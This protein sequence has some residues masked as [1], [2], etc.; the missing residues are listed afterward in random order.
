MEWLKDGRNKLPLRRGGWKRGHFLLNVLVSRWPV[1]TGVSVCVYRLGWEAPFH[2]PCWDQ[3]PH[4]ARENVYP[5]P[6][7]CKSTHTCTHAHTHTRWG[8][9]LPENKHV[10]SVQHLRSTHILFCRENLP[11]VYKL[12]SE[13]NVSVCILMYN[14]HFLKC[15]HSTNKGAQKSKKSKRLKGQIFFPKPWDDN[16]HLWWPTAVVWKALCMVT[17]RQ[18][19]TMALG[20]QSRN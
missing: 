6:H 3:H 16:Q 11:T 18:H 15:A 2:S 19:H 5:L 12:F 20:A 4:S 1:Q 10:I 8:A 13:V 17:W 7:M 9:T 14:R